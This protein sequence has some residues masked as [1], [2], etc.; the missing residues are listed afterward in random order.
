MWRCTC[1]CSGRRVPASG[2]SWTPSQWIWSRSS[3]TWRRVWR[4]SGSVA[5]WSARSTR[6]RRTTCGT[7]SRVLLHQLLPEP[8]FACRAQLAAAVE[9][10]SQMALLPLSQM[11]TAPD[12]VNRTVVWLCSDVPITSDV[13]L[14]VLRLSDEI[15]ELHATR[16]AVNKEVALLRSRDIGGDEND[17]V[18]DQMSS[19]LYVRKTIDHRIHRLQEGSDTDSAG[20]PSQ[21]D[22]SRLQAPGGKLFSLPLDVMLKNNVALSYFLE[23]MGTISEQ[24][25]L[26]FYLNVEGWRISAE[27]QLSALRAERRRGRSTD[28]DRLREAAQSIYE[29]YLSEKAQPRVRLDEALQKRLIFSI[30]S[31]PVVSETWFDEAQQSVYGRFMEERVYPAF[32]KTPSYLKLLAEL[33]L[34]KDA[35]GDDDDSQSTGS[36]GDSASVCSGDL[37]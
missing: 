7:V 29:Q 35:A 24:H 13:F 15:S 28:M 25:N 4:R 5:I 16:D 31:E 20:L 37:L 17:E 8:E 18:K 34:L 11:L 21:I 14:T 23:Y 12:F 33:D 26:F 2:S 10:L 22:W 6:T 30:R 36:G 9:L 32:K 27:Q 3:S 19:L 1:A